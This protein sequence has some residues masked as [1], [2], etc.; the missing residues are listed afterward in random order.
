[1]LCKLDLKKAYDRVDWDFLQY[2]DEA[3]GVWSQMERLD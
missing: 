3:I 2:Y 1:M